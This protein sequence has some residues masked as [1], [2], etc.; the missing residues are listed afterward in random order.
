[1]NVLHVNT[2][3]GW[4]GGEQQTLYLMRGLAAAGVRQELLCAQGGVLATRARESGLTVWER[5]LRGELDLPAMTAIARRIRAQAVDLVHMH[6]SHAHTLGVA[7]AVLSRRRP[8]TVVSRRVDFSIHKR[9]LFDF[10]RA[11]YTLGVD[12]ILCVSE[13]IRGVLLADGLRP[14]RLAVVHSGID[15][16]RFVDVPDR[17]AD[18]RRE[19]SVPAGAPVIGNVA[20]CAG[21]KGQRWL[22]AA[23]PAVLAACPEARAV[24]V[25][26]GELLEDLRAQAAS[27]G[28]SARVHFPGFRSDIPAL[29]R[30]FDVFCFPSVQEGLGTTVLD[31]L[32]LARP[33][34]ATTAGGIPEMIESG[35]HGLLVPPGQAEPLA[36]ALVALLRDRAGAAALGRAGQARVVAEFSVEQTVRRTLAEYRR[37]LPAAG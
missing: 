29:L 12:R 2:E 17:A 13:A 23:M 24:I 21:H 7:G 37:L 4:R 3:R 27:L 14:E 30:W 22:V 15:L 10:S 18:Y 31:A 8:A 5:P 19:F 33:V 16:S 6:T 26:E 36:Q 9:R 28:L 20:H 11:K 32:A 25:G 1:M 34:V 35:R